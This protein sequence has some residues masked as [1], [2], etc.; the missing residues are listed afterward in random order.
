M[1]EKTSTQSGEGKREQRIVQKMQ[2]PHLKP[3]LS[4]DQTCSC[5]QEKS[6]EG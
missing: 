4:A 2:H 1:G 3:P 6:G 5:S